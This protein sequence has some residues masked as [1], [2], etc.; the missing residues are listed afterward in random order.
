MR[1]LLGWNEKMAPVILTEDAN[2]I[3]RDQDLYDTFIDH[4]FKNSK[5][6]NTHR[7]TG[8]ETSA[9]LYRTH[10]ITNN[11]VEIDWDQFYKYQYLN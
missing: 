10:T 5:S 4:L 9:P 3:K 8:H 11:E 2:E 6:K 7:E 1:K